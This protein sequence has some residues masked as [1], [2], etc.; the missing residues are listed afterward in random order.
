MNTDL[1]AVVTGRDMTVKAR[2]IAVVPQ[3][4][5]TSVVTSRNVIRI[6][7]TKAR[8]TV[9]LVADASVVAK[10]GWIE[11]SPQARHATVTLVTRTSAKMMVT[12]HMGMKA[13][14]SDDI[15]KG[16][17]RGGK[18]VRA[19]RNRGDE[20]VAR[21]ATTPGIAVPTAVATMYQVRISHQKMEVEV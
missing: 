20:V 14:T 13:I 15:G 16:A 2:D 1:L 9:A 7:E 4:V 17:G 12:V 6:V 18:K 21:A 19:R 3:A 8:S 10:P 11:I 5:G